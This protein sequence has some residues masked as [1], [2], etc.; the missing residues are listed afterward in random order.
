MA[1]PVSTFPAILCKL[2]QKHRSSSKCMA[3]VLQ[4][5]LKLL[6]AI[7]TQSPRKKR[8]LLQ[9]CESRMFG[10]RS[11]DCLSVPS[12][13]W[14]PCSSLAATFR[15]VL[16]LFANVNWV[17]DLFVPDSFVNVN[18]MPKDSFV[19][20]SLENVNWT[21][22]LFMTHSRMNRYHVLAA[23]WHLCR[24]PTSKDQSL[25][26]VPLPTCRLAIEQNWTEKGTNQF[27]KWSRSV[28]SLERVV[29]FKWIVP[30][31]Y[32]TIHL[33]L[34]EYEKSTAGHFNNGM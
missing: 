15:F 16:D 21:V 10:G 27:R 18:W 13:V 29:L 26:V 33:T 20:D 17:T 5:P 12:T 11:N 22:D 19:P 30:E 14:L 2:Q 9:A 25:H 1:A 31:W 34:S 23:G 6:L 28:H 3:E 4:Q 24:R 8:D 32:N 7:L